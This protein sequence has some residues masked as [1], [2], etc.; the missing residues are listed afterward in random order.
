MAHRGEPIGQLAGATPR[1]KANLSYWI[2]R[3]NLEAGL[4]VPDAATRSP[5]SAVLQRLR[6]ELASLVPTLDHATVLEQYP[7]TPPAADRLFYLMREFLMQQEICLPQEEAAR[8]DIMKEYFAFRLAAAACTEEEELQEFW[9]HI[10]EQQWVRQR[11]HQNMNLQFVG[12]ATWTLRAR[13]WV[14]EQLREQG[15]GQQVFVA[16]WFDPSLD[17]TYKNGFAQ[18]IAQAGYTPHRVDEDNLHSDKLDDRV[19]AGIRRSRIVVADFTC[20]E[21]CRAGSAT[22]EGL[23]NGNVY[24]E[25]GFAHGLGLPVIYTCREDCQDYLRFDTRQINHILWKDSV[26]LARRLQD[27]LEGQF[28]HGPVQHTPDV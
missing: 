25:A 7:R 15:T 23:T 16:M 27:R 3:Q 19:M 24:Y 17:Q 22:P 14:E 8:I 5:R 26:D 28:G 18:G 1:E 11:D 21:F 20:E 9:T 12:P 4:L 10:D 13:L 2:Y 6:D